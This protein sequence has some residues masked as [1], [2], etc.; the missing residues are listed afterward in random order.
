MLLEVENVSYSY[1]TRDDALREISFSLAGGQ[2]LGLIGPNG[3]GKSTLTKL[4]VDLLQLRRG[5]IRVDRHRNSNK[6]AKTSSIYL[7]SNE[8]MP[9][10]LTGAEYLRF[11]HSLYGEPLDTATMDRYFQR[12]QMRN[13]SGDLIEDYSHGMRKKLQLI[14]ALMLKRKLSV[15]DETLNGIDLDAVYSFKEDVRLLASNGRS[16]V[17][18]SHDFRMLETVADRVLLL[19]HGIL[20]IDSS[21]AAVLEQYGSL[22]LLVE[23]FI[24]AMR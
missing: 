6:R 12:Y 9:E 24:A 14:S 16:V 13:R 23:D 8:N 4:I 19:N 17:L 18:C 7:A 11:I 1:N 5:R 10:F 3:S 21:T 2:I 15:I 22:D 20:A